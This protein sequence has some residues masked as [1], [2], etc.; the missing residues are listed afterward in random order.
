[1]NALNTL[2]DV[3]NLTLARL[4]QPPINSLDD[5]SAVA[6]SVRLHMKQAIRSEQ[7]L[8]DWPELRQ[9]IELAKDATDHTDGRYRYALVPQ[10]LAIRSADAEF[11]RY[12]AWL[13]SEA[14]PLTVTVTVYSEDVATW[15]TGLLECISLA[16]AILIGP[17][18][19]LNMG[20][21]QDLRAE[22]EKIARP[23][24]LAAAA[25]SD[26]LEENPAGDVR[27]YRGSNSRR[28]N[29]SYVG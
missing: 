1:M 17:A 22:L 5:V 16:L 29:G 2:T 20:A 14:D 12:A 21:A 25:N 27:N 9:E 8:A 7:R 13:L 15:S 18:L 3:A 6:A 10:W 19:S 4:G 28:L 11:A 26:S 24:A 23:R